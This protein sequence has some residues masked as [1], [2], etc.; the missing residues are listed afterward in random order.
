MAA[1]NPPADRGHQASHAPG[2]DD[3]HQ[4][5][6]K[7]PRQL[8]T[9]I[10]LAF[11]IPILVIIMLAKF[12][13]SASIPAAGTNAMSDEAV[14]ERLRPV[15]GFELRAAN[16]G[17]A[18]SPDDV[19]KATCSA[20]HGAGVAGAPKTGDTDAWAPRIAQGIEA[21]FHSALKGKGAMPPQGGGDFS[22][23]E[24][25]RTVVML[26]NKGGGQFSDPPEPGAKGGEGGEGE[27]APAGESK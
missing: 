20:C 8:V 5:P 18:R 19:Y 27:A 3:D 23:F 17:A 2:H 14:R 22:D 21:L 15:A 4:S 25:E 24:I 9:V 11:V 12:V 13:A 10:V 6:I 1:H 7:T 26:A 16:G